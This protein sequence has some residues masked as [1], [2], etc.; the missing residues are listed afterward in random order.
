MWELFPIAGNPIKRASNVIVASLH[1][2]SL[3]V[4]R[5]L[6]TTAHPRPNGNKPGLSRTSGV[7]NDQPNRPTLS[8]SHADQNCK[9]PKKKKKKKTNGILI[10]C[11]LIG[12]VCLAGSIFLMWSTEEEILERMLEV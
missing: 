4:V 8:L 12:L 11:Y 1:S 7:E 9:V 10:N 2:Q 5:S 3:G 6:P